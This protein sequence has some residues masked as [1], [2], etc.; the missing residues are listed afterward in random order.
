[1]SLKLSVVAASINMR[2]GRSVR[3]HTIPELPD[4]SPDC[5]PCVIIGRCAERAKAGAV[6]LPSAFVAIA[7]ANVFKNRRRV[8]A[9]P[10]RKRPDMSW[11]PPNHCGRWA[12]FL[13]AEKR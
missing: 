2:A 9:L 3:A 10:V 4:T 12:R 13:T 5:T 11:S 6:R 7:E 1:M 8:V